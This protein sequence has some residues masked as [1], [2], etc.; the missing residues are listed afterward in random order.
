M[1]ED[2]ANIVPAD[3]IRPSFE[4]GLDPGLVGVGLLGQGFGSFAQRTSEGS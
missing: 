3:R 1:S 2:G 4:K